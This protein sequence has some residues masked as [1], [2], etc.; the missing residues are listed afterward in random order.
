MHSAPWCIG[1]L[2]S[3]IIAQAVY[4]ESVSWTSPHIPYDST[5]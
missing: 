3:N 4:Y 2:R 1:M 5:R